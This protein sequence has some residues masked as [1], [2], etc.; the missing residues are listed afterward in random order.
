MRYENIEFKV[1][2]LPSKTVDLTFL[3][4]EANHNE[5]RVKKGLMH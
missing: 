3:R 1:V 5:N 4:R 2:L